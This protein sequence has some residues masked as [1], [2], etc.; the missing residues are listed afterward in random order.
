MCTS[1]RTS[2]R[3]P[4]PNHA[5]VRSTCHRRL[6]RRHWRPCGNGAFTRGRRWGHL[7]SRPRFARRCRRGSASQAFSSSTRAGCWRGRP[8]PRRGTALGSRLG[9]NRVTAAGDAESQRFPT[10]SP[11]PS[12]PTIH[13][14]PLPPVVLPT[15]APLVS[16][17]QSGRQHRVQPHRV[18]LG[19]PGAPSTRATPSAPRLGRPSPGGAARRYWG[20]ETA[21][22]SLASG[23]RFAAP[24]GGRR[25]QAKAGGGSGRRL[26]RPCVQVTRERSCPTAPP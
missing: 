25:R 3:R 18:G 24:R 16:P 14:V 6:S 8:G 5:Q 13:C 2:R 23:R 19:R 7:S 9:S 26:A 12:T 4:L 1:Q 11:W 20:T 21:L 10:G 22:A 15:Q 17:G